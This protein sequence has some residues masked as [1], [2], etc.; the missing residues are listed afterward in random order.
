[1]KKQIK[2][3]LLSSILSVSLLAGC[4]S[5][6]YSED[7]YSAADYNYASGVA[8]ESYYDGY[9]EEYGESYDYPTEA[10]AEESAS[11]EN[12]PEVGEDAANTRSDRKLIRT[13]DLEVETRNFMEMTS[14]IKERTE[15]LGGY[16]ESSS[17]YGSVGGEYRIASYTLRIPADKAD[18]F[19]DAIVEGSNITYRTENVE[20]VTLTY[21]DIDSRKRSLQIEYDRLEELL[22]SAEEIEDLITIEERLSQVRYEIQSIESQLRTYDNKVNYTTIYLS[23]NEVFDYTPPEVYN[24]TYFERLG[25]GL[26]TAFEDIWDGAQDFSIFIIVAIPYL[27]ALGIPVVIILLIVNAC[28]KKHKKK[29]AKKAAENPAPVQTAGASPQANNESTKSIPYTE[30][31][32]D[33][34]SKQDD[35]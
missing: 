11:G 26:K 21:V 3:V 31:Q 33:N 8:S 24:P 7:A 14:N 5:S 4:G 15:A 19:I 27:I 25:N 13:I 12:A 35:K 6:K 18:S 10:T 2:I 1:M 17:A 9:Y 34:T 28:V 23:I 32:N 16:V 20:D 29:L 30:R 22:K